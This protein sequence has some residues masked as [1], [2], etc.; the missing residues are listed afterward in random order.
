M[1]PLKDKNQKKTIL[2]IL[3]SLSKFALPQWKEGKMYKPIKLKGS[4]MKVLREDRPLH[5][6]VVRSMTFTFTVLY[7]AY[8]FRS[9]FELQPLVEC[10]GFTL[11]QTKLFLVVVPVRFRFEFSSNCYVN[12]WIKSGILNQ[13]MRKDGGDNDEGRAKVVSQCPT[14]EFD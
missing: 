1:S 4:W 3:L 2:M 6:P 13:K 11:N 7:I 12:Q 8:K 14:G 9:L 10:Y 5:F